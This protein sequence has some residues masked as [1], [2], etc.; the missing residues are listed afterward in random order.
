MREYGYIPI[1][2]T[3][4]QDVFIVGYPKSGNTWM[5]FMITSIING[6]D[7]SFLNLSIVFEFVPDVHYKKIYKRY[8]DIC[9]FKSHDYPKPEHRKVIYL[10][11]DGRDAMISY[12]HMNKIQFREY[13]M[14]DMILKGVGLFP[15]KW[16]EH[17]SAWMK[18]PYDS[19]ILFIKYEDLK[20]DA[21]REMRRVCDFLHF[22]IS[23]ERLLSVIDGCSFE[24]LKSLE[25][26]QGLKDGEL[27]WKGD[28]SN[29][30]FRK[31]EVGNF[32]DSLGSNLLSAFEME[33]SEQ[34]KAFGYLIQ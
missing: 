27:V 34:L 18:N 16:H 24:K 11:R 17:I 33:S 29:R 6:I 3:Q 30:F 12:Y 23:E 7:P 13:S 14:E 22:Q 4:P 26:N 19:Q 31:G 28:K 20:N 32:R 8:R 10:V 21:L 2:E 15:G 9:F 25:V 1:A 5:Q